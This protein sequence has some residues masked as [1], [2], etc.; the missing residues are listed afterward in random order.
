MSALKST[1]RIGALVAASATAALV[2]GA[3][4]PAGIANANPDEGFSIVKTVSPN[5]GVEA[6]DTVTY[7]FRVINRTGA[8][9]PAVIE[10]RNFSGSS[11][12]SAFT[13]DDPEFSGGAITADVNVA[14]TCT[15]TYVVTQQDVDSCELTNTAGTLLLNPEEPEI[16]EPDARPVVPP[17]EGETFMSTA[18]I[19]FDTPECAES[20]VP[21]PGS[22]GSLG[23]ESLGS[24]ALGSAALGSVALGSIG[25]NEPSAPEPS[26]PEPSTPESSAPEP[27]SPEHTEPNAPKNP[28]TTSPTGTRPHAIDGGSADMSVGNSTVGFG[29]AAVLLALGAAGAV[30]ATR[31]TR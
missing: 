18:T 4:L 29:V 22:S 23:T 5:V 27:G 31:R 11:E 13:C 17:A 6:G 21:G 2:G 9:A 14:T 25:S 26:A 12:L 30:L 3:L 8:L 1:K 7:T 10:E 15:A 28:G 16:R 19:S 24:A 20:V